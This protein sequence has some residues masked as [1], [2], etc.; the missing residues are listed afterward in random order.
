MRPVMRRSYITSAIAGALVL[1]LATAAVAA[2]KGE[3][4]NMCTEGLA[5]GKDVAT[6]CSVNATIKGKTYCFGSEQAKS[7]FMKDPEGNLAKAP[8]LLS[9]QASG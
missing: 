6:D 1:G 9:K 5:L 3:F 4:N 8:G 2:T 7:N